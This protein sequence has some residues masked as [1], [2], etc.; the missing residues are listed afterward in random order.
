MPR[1]RQAQCTEVHGTNYEMGT[2]PGNFE[3]L[4]AYFREGGELVG[5]ASPK[6]ITGGS[7]EEG[8]RFGD[9]ELETGGSGL[10]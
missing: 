10:R 8:G 6:C 9:T 7:V 5:F 2:C 3:E 1:G 4:L